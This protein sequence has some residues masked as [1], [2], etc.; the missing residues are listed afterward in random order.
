[1][2]H[3][4]HFPACLKPIYTQMYFIFWRNWVFQATPLP[5]PVLPFLRPKIFCVTT[6]RRL[7]LEIYGIYVAAIFTAK[8]TH[9]KKI[10]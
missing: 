10:L 3:V 6:T 7:F 1:M 5:Q 4:F 2:A 9:W 8:V